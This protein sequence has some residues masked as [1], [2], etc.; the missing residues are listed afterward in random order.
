[1]KWTEGFQLFLQQIAASNSSVFQ[2]YVTN[3]NQKGKSYA[4]E[5]LI[6]DYVKKMTQPSQREGGNLSTEGVSLA[7]TP[8]ALTEPSCK[9]LPVADVVYHLQG[10]LKIYNM[11]YVPLSEKERYR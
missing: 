3:Q 4:F 6:R 7:S 9:Q 1:V 11:V 5:G 8:T 10:G 2:K